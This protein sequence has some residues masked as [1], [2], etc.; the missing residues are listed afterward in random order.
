MFK[1]IVWASDGSEHAD[2]AFDYAKGLQ[3]LVP[4]ISSPCT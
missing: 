1:V 2:R 4:L 3:K